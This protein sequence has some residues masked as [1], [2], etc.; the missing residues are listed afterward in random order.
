MKKNYSQRLRMNLIALVAIMC[1]V[2][3]TYSQNS[4]VEQ[5][6]SDLS[7][8]VK[9]NE[10]RNTRD[11]CNELIINAEP[12]SEYA[13]RSR[14]ILAR[15]A[16]LEGEMSEIYESYVYF[17]AIAG[18]G[19]TPENY[20]AL[21]KELK[22]AY[23]S[24]LIEDMRQPISEGVY[25]SDYH[26]IKHCPLVL[27]QIKR[28]DDGW[29]AIQ[30]PGG[31]VAD[32]NMLCKY[33]GIRAESEIF[34]SDTALIYN[35]FWS[36]MHS[37]RPNTE[38]AH[39][40]IN[41]SQKFKEEMYGEMARGKYGTG[42]VLAGTVATEAIGGLMS[43]LGS[44]LS[45]GKVTSCISELD[46]TPIG[47]GQLLATFTNTT[48]EERTGGNVP[49]YEKQHFDFTLF[50]LYPHHKIFFYDSPND[51]VVTSK[52]RIHLKYNER[53]YKL[54]EQTHPA[55]FD[56]YI[57]SKLSK[58]KPGKKIIYKLD[59]LK[60]LNGLMYKYWEYN[61]LFA[62]LKTDPMFK[63]AL[64]LDE[65]E[66]VYVEG[67]SLVLG[68]YEKRI[69]DFR[70]FMAF[71]MKE[72]H[73]VYMQCPENLL[74]VKRMQSTYFTDSSYLYGEFIGARQEGKCYMKYTDGS[75]YEGHAIGMV[76]NGEGTRTWQDGL[77]YTGTYKEG[78]E[79]DGVA[80]YIGKDFSY[81]REVRDGV[82]DSLATITYSDGNIY[83]G[84]TGKH[85]CPDG[86]GIMTYANG[87]V[88]KGQ[89]ENG[90]LVVNKPTAKNARKRVSNKKKIA[91]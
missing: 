80:I 31:Q 47:N 24:L 37:R 42:D 58:N 74:N 49:K 81:K 63:M 6:W 35:A 25:F 65:M 55:F 26:D 57:L 54:F 32:D 30:L 67:G 64:P 51:C 52:E 79:I 40:T 69:N 22:A 86:I 66:S 21:K 61:T 87:K 18:K 44:A 17:D 39:S 9:K 91:K 82:V 71:R 4:H 12:F 88:I 45:K 73:L 75:T 36:G 85:Y 38:M 76:R 28:S 43:L 2:Q 23:D 1:A 56:D 20:I 59:K 78:K 83:K 19:F 13:Q 60:D 41:E 46:W 48:K 29:K 15:L 68:K 62:S 5:L 90:N 7:E 8:A 16:L 84:K 53:L 11:K 50:K 14:Y 70:S 34:Q 72:G 77:T 10:V 89:W 33:G 27:L 3:A